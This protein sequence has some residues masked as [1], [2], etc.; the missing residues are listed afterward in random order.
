MLRDPLMLA[1]DSMDGA[2]AWNAPQANGLHA[3]VLGTGADE[4]E[5]LAPSD[6]SDDE[7]TDVEQQ[8]K[9]RRGRPT[10]ATAADW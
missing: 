8:P 6:A 1:L 5:S 2:L 9:R 3:A 7:D 4:A 10:A